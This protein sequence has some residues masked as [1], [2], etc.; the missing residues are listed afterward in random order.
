MNLPVDIEARPRVSP[1]EI[2]AHWRPQLFDL[3][4]R[5]P[6]GEGAQWKRC[7]E[8]QDDVV[9]EVFTRFDPEILTAD[10]ILAFAEG[11]NEPRRTRGESKKTQALRGAVLDVLER[12]DGSLSSRQVF[13]QCV[14][15]GAVSNCKA[16]C[17]RVG[18]LLVAMRRDGSVPYDRIVDRTRSKHVLPSWEGL[19][20][21]LEASAEQY[22]VDYWRTQSV[23][24]MIACEKQALEGIFAET[25][26]EHGVPLWVIRG[27]NSESFEYEWAEDIKAIVASG[28]AVV[29]YYF[30]DHDPSGL[31][32]EAN[33]KRKLEAFG[34]RFTWER[35]GLL[36]EDFERF[37][38]VN[39]PVKQ[40]DTRAKAYL[41]QFG[42]RAAELDALHPDELRRRIGAV[43][44]RHINAQR[45]KALVRG[46]EAGRES[47]RAIAGN[48]PKALQAVQGAA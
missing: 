1:A 41:S 15:T 28:R 31:C 19:A 47:L 9:A 48:V 8:L 35:A 16:E 3:A 13:Y 10:M 40:T 2:A 33:S 18:R 12:I 14:S 32:I 26:D 46:Q 4:R 34:A 45:W 44:G 29:V 20:Q 38:L 30:G 39:V 36:A 11:M 23:V 6:G 42:D 43:V 27:F 37:G 25:V 21:I 7:A 17:L 22:R 24:P 5:A